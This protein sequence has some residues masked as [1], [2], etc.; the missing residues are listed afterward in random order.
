MGLVELL[1]VDDRPV[2]IL[3]LTSPSKTIPV[4]YNASLQAIPLLV[5]KI[6]KGVIAGGKTERD[7]LYMLRLLNGLLQRRDLV[8]SQK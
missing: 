6:G 3:D 4:Y 1:D 8:A 5:L 7:P 2:F